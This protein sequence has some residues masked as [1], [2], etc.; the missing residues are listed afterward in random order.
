[1]NLSRSIASRDVALK[2]LGL[3][4]GSSPEEVRSAYRRLAFEYHPDRHTGNPEMEARFKEIG[5]AYQELNS[6][7]FPGDDSTV[8]PPLQKGQDLYYD[9]RM[10][11]ITAVSGGDVS[12][13]IKRPFVCPSCD[14]IFSKSCRECDGDGAILEEAMVRVQLPTG[15]E[16]GELVR[17]PHEG[18]PGT[19]GGGPGDLVL[20]VR[21]S[22][23]PAFERCG[24]DVHS[25]VRVPRFRLRRGGPVRVFTVRGGAQVDIPP[26]TPPGR[27]F[28]LRG[29]GIERSR[30]GRTFRGDHV[31]RILAMPGEEV[32]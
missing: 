30:D 12:V 14:G 13:L 11:F 24:V 27:T 6:V 25:E 7:Y 29:W 16:D 8:R 26:G 21:C 23:H 19:G 3:P 31:V 10:D 9:I 5:R 2:I 20:T 4:P 1:M 32:S 22:R 18:A 15:L 17:V 28:R